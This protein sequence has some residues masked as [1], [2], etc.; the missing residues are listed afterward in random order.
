MIEG[1]LISFDTSPIFMLNNLRRMYQKKIKCHGTPDS[2]VKNVNLKRL[3][4]ASINQVL[5]LCE[6]KSGKLVSLTLDGVIGKAIF[7]FSI[8]SPKDEE[9]ILGN[10]AKIIRIFSNYLLFNGDISEEKQSSLVP[11]CLLHLLPLI[12]DGTTNYHKI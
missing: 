12:L 1:K 6:Q 9:I 5:G 3:T 7:Q 2:A 11:S 4:E 8:N 10:S